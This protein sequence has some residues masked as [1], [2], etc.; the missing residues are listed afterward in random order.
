MPGTLGSAKIIFREDTASKYNTTESVLINKKLVDD[1]PYHPG[2]E[3]AVFNDLGRPL[4]Q[5]I[6]SKMLASGKRFWAGDNVSDFVTEQDKEVLIT[7]ATKAF[8]QVLDTLLIDRHNDPNS[9]GTARRLAKM[10]F[11][12]IMSGRYDP[13]PDAT[14]FPNDTEDRYEGMLVVRSELRSMCSH[15]HQPVSGVAY[16]GIIAAQKLIGLSKYTRIAQWCARRG[17]LQE[18][19]ANDIAREIERA[20]GAEDLG[21][22]IQA[23]HGCCENRGIMAHSSLTQTTVL[24]GAFKNDAGTKKEFFDNIKLQQEFAPR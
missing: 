11:N 12:E 16:I 24:K 14:A 10:Y 23:T 22:Y 15:H 1:A 6:R 18:E 9:K 7:E 19:L 5:V 21:V 17:T 3:G 13:R 2:Y 20:T 8:E 4:S